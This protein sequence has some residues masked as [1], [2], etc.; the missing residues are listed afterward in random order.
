MSVG[1]Q[2]QKCKSEQVFGTTERRDD[3][4]TARLQ[5]LFILLRGEITHLGLM[6]KKERLLIFSCVGIF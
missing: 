2:H 3:S 1:K 5:M 4:H 6:F